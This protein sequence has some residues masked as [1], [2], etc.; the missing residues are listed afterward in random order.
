MKSGSRGLSIRQVTERA[1]LSASLVGPIEC[2]RTNPSLGTLAELASVL[3]VR[4]AELFDTGQR[5]PR[6]ARWWER[7]REAVAYLAHGGKP[8]TLVADLNRRMELAHSINDRKSWSG[9]VPISH[10]DEK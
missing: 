1:G 6:K 2:S 3:R 8:P 7:S 9:E 4:V 10:A 5:G